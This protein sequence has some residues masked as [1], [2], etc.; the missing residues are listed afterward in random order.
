MPK[1]NGCLSDHAGE[2]REEREN[3]KEVV[4]FPLCAVG[5]RSAA[6]QTK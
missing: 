4:D 3:A 1:F 2:T 5:T 6:Q